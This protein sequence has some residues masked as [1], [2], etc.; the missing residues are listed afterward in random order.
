MATASVLVDEPIVGEIIMSEFAQKA[1]DFPV[2]ATDRPMAT[3]ESHSPVHRAD[4]VSNDHEAGIQR[5]LYDR[6]SANDEPLS[7]EPLYVRPR[8]CAAAHERSMGSTGGTGQHC[9]EGDL[10][11]LADA[12]FA[13]HRSRS[14]N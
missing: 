3:S 7:S 6:G 1:T 8:C 12:R 9:G 5:Y 13:P 10:T 2:A 4:N 11:R 14:G